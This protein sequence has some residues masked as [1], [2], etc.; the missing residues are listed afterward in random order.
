[1]RRWND[2][3]KRLSRFWLLGFRPCSSCRLVASDEGMH[4]KDGWSTFGFS[5]AKGHHSR[6]Y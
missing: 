5:R 1:M 3:M 6:R 2:G 4:M